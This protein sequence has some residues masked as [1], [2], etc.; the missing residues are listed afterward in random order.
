MSIGL[1]GNKIGIT[2]IFTEEG[3]AIPVT[4]IQVGPC[5]ITQIKT[6]S[7]DNYD[8]IQI[9][10]SE[11]N[12]KK[13]TKAQLGHLKKTNSPPLAFLKEY[14]VSNT[15]DFSLGQHLNIENFKVGQLLDVTGKSVGK[16]FSGNQ[17]RHNF[18]RGPMSHGSKNHRA[19]GS[20]G[21]GTTPGRIFPGKKMAGRLGGGNSTVSKLKILG[22]NHKQN[23]L[24]IKGSIPGKPG[25]L[26]NIISS[27][28]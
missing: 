12:K 4:V 14:R 2:Q 18:K 11:V 20:I 26:I 21:A 10:Y 9:G 15:E 7:K 13:L 27:K 24:I 8:A 16:G 19:P 25:N 22:I 23:L 3:L 1:F 5:I 17:K 6:K 28:L